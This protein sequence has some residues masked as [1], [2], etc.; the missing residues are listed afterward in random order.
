MSGPGYDPLDVGPTP[1]ARDDAVDFISVRT[2]SAW[3]DGTQALF[4]IEAPHADG[5]RL[6][7]GSVGLLH[8]HDGVREII[9]GVHPQVRGRGVCR[10]AVRLLVDWGF[11]EYGAELV[12]WRAAVGNWAA[13]RVAW[14]TGFTFDGMVTSLGSQRGERRDIWIGSLRPDDPREAPAPLAHPPVDDL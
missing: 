10:R 4:A 5:T 13:R 1:Y 11:S 12:L 6:F 3:A 9:F 14:S 2:P 7:S 8:R